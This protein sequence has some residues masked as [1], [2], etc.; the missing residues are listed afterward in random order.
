MLSIFPSDQLRAT[1]GQAHRGI[2]WENSRAFVPEWHCRPL[3]VSD[4]AN[5]TVWKHQSVNKTLLCGSKGFQHSS[6]R[7]GGVHVCVYGGGGGVQRLCVSLLSSTRRPPARL[8][9]EN[10]YHYLGKPKDRVEKMFFLPRNN[11]GYFFHRIPLLPRIIKIDCACNFQGRGTKNEAGA[12]RPIVAPGQIQH[13]HIVAVKWQFCW[14]ANS[15]F[16]F[17]KPFKNV[18]WLY[19]FRIISTL[20]YIWTRFE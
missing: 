15:F 2:I 18:L 19:P 20:L 12:E 16:S 9:R 4:S 11:Q 8:T 1:H 6:R 14:V 17:R 7:Q 10:Y 5:V 13:C 3:N